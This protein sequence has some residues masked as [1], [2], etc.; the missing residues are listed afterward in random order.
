MNFSLSGIAAGLV[1]G[2]WGMILL[3]KGK[4]DAHIPNMV[5]GLSLMIYPYFIENV[6]LLWGVG[7][8]LI[9]LAYKLRYH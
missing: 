1:F 3:K 9:V 4:T 5:I 2:F 6:Y 7:F 8:A